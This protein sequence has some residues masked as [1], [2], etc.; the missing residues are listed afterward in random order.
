MNHRH[1]ISEWLSFGTFCVQIGQL[2]EAQ[3]VSKLSE[4]FLHCIDDIFLRYQ[5]FVDVQAFFKD[6][7]C[8]KLLTNLDQ[9]KRK[10]LGYKLLYQLFQKCYFVHERWAVKN[11]LITSVCYAT[12]SL[13][14]TVFDHLKLIFSKRSNECWFEIKILSITHMILSQKNSVTLYMEMK[15]KWYS[16]C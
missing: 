11:A 8:L 5:R 7:L 3:W 2:F 4:E 14:W 12:D 9:K 15:R 10:D 13:F 16:K 6:P 1:I